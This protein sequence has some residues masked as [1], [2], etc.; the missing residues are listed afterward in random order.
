MSK[1]LLT[2]LPEK[3][4][5]GTTNEHFVLM[6][7]AERAWL[8]RDYRLAAVVA[9]TWTLLGWGIQWL[10]CYKAGREEWSR[11]LAAAT[12][13]KNRRLLRAEARGF[14]R[15]LASLE[16]VGIV[17]D[18][19]VADARWPD[20]NAPVEPPQRQGGATEAVA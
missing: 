8:T 3:E 20:R 16:A 4:R 6:A 17:N 10:D 18:E 12:Y 1:T 7:V 5:K 15:C 11:F 9:A 2:T 19:S 13:G 14:A